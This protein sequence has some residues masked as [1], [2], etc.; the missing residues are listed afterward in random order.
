MRRYVLLAAAVSPI[1]AMAG[2]VS[3]PGCGEEFDDVC[4][5]LKDPNSCY[6]TFHVETDARCA[7]PRAGDEPTGRFA[8]R[9]TLDVCFLT[10]GG[11]VV[12]DPPLDL[13]AFPP[14]N[15]T[16]KR[17]DA[18]AQECGSFTFSGEFNY[19]VSIACNQD[20]VEAGVASCA[21]AGTPA[22]DG[23]VSVRGTATIT[24]PDGRDTLD[25][26]CADGT[27]HHFNRID[28][29]RKCADY[30]QLLPRAVLKTSLGNQPP[31]NAGPAAPE[32]FEGFISLSVH[33]PPRQA[34]LNSDGQIEAGTPAEV[35]EYFY[36]EFP[37]PPA[38]CFNGVKDG[39]ETDIDCGGTLCEGRCGDG[40]SCIIGNNDCATGL[41]C[42][43]VDGFSKC[44]APT[45]D[46]GATSAAGA[47]GAD[48]AG[49]AAGAGGQ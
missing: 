16:F 24:T 21:D 28:A 25:V 20:D 45:E 23:T 3:V 39:P 37:A 13:T 2:V 19:S 40:Q 34:T 27:S 36:C 10:S 42:V 35:V 29:E 48:G 38:L 11:Q 30:E 18:Q 47:G 7:V 8:S 32:G 1:V 5:F 44:K 4:A 22:E 46:G 15:L 33:H 26:S 9:E 17:L 14:T 12:F 6:R 41:E 31:P 49:G 43:L